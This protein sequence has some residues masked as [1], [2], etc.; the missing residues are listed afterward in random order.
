MNLEKLETNR[1]NI[2]TW[3]KENES[4]LNDALEGLLTASEVATNDDE[5]IKYWS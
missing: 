3:M 2:R 1:N 5:S 4:P